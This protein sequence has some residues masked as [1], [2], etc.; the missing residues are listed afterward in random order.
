M[1]HR[2]ITLGAPKASLRGVVLLLATLMCLPALCG[3]TEHVPAGKQ[4]APAPES[5][6]SVVDS[7]TAQAEPTV[8]A[9][10][11]PLMAEKVADF[12]QGFVLADAQLMASTLSPTNA[13][14]VL[15]AAPAIAMGGAIGQ[16]VSVD[17]D[18]SGILIITIEEDETSYTLVPLTSDDGVNLTVLTWQGSADE[19]I[20]ETEITYTFVDNDGEYVID[21]IDG[22]TASGVVVQ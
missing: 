13:A 14:S 22:S 7:A 21:L 20:S 1:F 15:E 5:S 12:I 16:V 19:R 9:Q 18:A 4:P 3:C 10:P 17:Q 8:I 2:M 11:G 6:A